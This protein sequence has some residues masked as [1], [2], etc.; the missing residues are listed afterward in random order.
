MHTS[1]LLRQ[2]LVDMPPGAV[3]SSA[4]FLAIGTRAAL[5]QALCR[6]VR[7]GDIVRVARGLYA[8]AGQAVDSRTV[9]MALAQ[10]TGEQVAWHASVIRSNVLVVPTSGISRTVNSAGHA[11]HFQRV[12]QRK[13]RLA[14]SPQGRVLLELWMRGSKELTTME[15]RRA[16]GDWAPDDIARYAAMVPEWLRIAVQATNAPR[17]SARIGLTGAY[18]WS[19]PNMK[20]D[21]LIG[22]VLERLKFEDVAHLCFFY[23]VAKVKRVFKLREFEYPTR[24]SLA[25]MLGNIHKG[26]LASEGRA[27]DGRPLSALQKDD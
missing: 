6:M 13:V 4:D 2:A 5:D 23:G 8:A 21:V 24:A 25:R 10:K 22:K 14:A 9:A 16:I 18:D 20:D 3:F 12:S 26:M 7:A 1:Q 17:K 19:N 27:K 15:I 11:V